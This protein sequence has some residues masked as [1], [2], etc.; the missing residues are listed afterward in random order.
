MFVFTEPITTIHG[1]PDLYID[2]GSTVN[3]TCIVK[4]LPE[5]PA[6]I[7]WTHNNE[8]CSNYMY[9]YI[10]YTWNREPTLTFQPQITYGMTIMNWINSGECNWNLLLLHFWE[11]EL[12]MKFIYSSY[13]TNNSSWQVSAIWMLWAFSV[14]YILDLLL[15][16]LVYEYLIRWIVRKTH[17]QLE[18]FA[19]LERT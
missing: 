6:T 7:Q 15:N 9:S 19:R 18:I 17:T 5:P 14:L 10:V 2:T 4:H 8:V 11:R 12:L 13:S 3:L 1:S 16:L